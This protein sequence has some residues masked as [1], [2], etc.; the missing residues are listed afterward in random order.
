VTGFELPCPKRNR[1]PDWTRSR[2]D[3]TP[4]WRGFGW[5]WDRRTAN[6]GRKTSGSWSASLRPPERG[7]ESRYFN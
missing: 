5:R 4:W 3:C 7:K 1:T 6:N 2:R